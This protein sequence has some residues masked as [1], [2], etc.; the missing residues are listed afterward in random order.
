MDEKGNPD[1]QK[2]EGPSLKKTETIEN[3]DQVLLKI[4]DENEGIELMDIDTLAPSGEKDTGNLIENAD[5]LSENDTDDIV[6]LT[7]EIAVPVD[8]LEDAFV[9][10]TSDEVEPL[11][12]LFKD[13]VNLDDVIQE[14]QAGE[15]TEDD[16]FINDL[17]M[18]LDESPD[19][20][21]LATDDLS[22]LGDGDQ[23]AAISLTEVQIEAAVERVVKKVFS[24]KI[25]RMLVEAID[26]T[27]KQEIEKLKGLIE[28][29]TDNR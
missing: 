16:H 24:E 27:I 26:K 7:E 19:N 9:L 12:D 3:K 5:M 14:E 10:D 11:D 29:A 17:G 4:E 25:E 15:S 13:A 20:G 6:E 28:D 1:V 8:D 23:R 18:A 21:E 2:E 22:I